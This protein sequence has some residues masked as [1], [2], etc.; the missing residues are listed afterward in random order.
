MSYNSRVRIL[1]VSQSQPPDDDDSFYDRLIEGEPTITETLIQ[2]VLVMT[3][4]IVFIRFLYESIC[5]I[6]NFFFG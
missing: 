6:W 4:I 3:G 1:V 5:S 2:V